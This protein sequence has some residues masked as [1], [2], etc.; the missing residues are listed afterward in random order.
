MFSKNR[1]ERFKLRTILIFA[2]YSLGFS[3]SVFVFN[4]TLCLISIPLMEQQEY[5][6]LKPLT[7][8]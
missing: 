5:H 6:D 4:I 2:T 1:L 3:S 7:S 8:I